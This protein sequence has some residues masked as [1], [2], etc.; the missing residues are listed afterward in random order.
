[1]GEGNE[2]GAGGTVGDVF[3]RGVATIG[4]AEN[5]LGALSAAVVA[6]I[7]HLHELESGAADLFAQAQALADEAEQAE[8]DA[9][10]ELFAQAARARAE[11]EE[12]ERAEQQAAAELAAQAD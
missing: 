8:G 11:A 12:L 5:A 1:G 2:V 9:G 10:T 3:N 6:E 4:A 7:N